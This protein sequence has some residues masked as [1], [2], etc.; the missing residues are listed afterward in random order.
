MYVIIQF[1]SHHCA[2]FHHIPFLMIRYP[3][4]LFWLSSTFCRQWF[5]QTTPLYCPIKK[6]MLNK[7]I[8]PIWSTSNFKGKRSFQKRTV[9][10]ILLFCFW[11]LHKFCD[12][13]SVFTEWR[14]YTKPDCHNGLLQKNIFFLLRKWNSFGLKWIKECVTLSLMTN[15][16]DVQQELL[17]LR[18]TF[19]RSSSQQLEFTWNLKLW[20]ICNHGRVNLERSLQRMMIS[21]RLLF[22][23]N[24]S[25]F[26]VYNLL[27]SNSR[28]WLTIPTSWNKRVG[29]FHQYI[30]SDLPLYLQ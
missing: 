29:F 12:F 17:T 6:I 19:S 27:I 13:C 4:F 7:W 9:W 26:K 21:L 30:S 10:H 1:P 28:P 8:F 25:L 22:Q 15:L 3:I 20:A 18:F 23:V 14:Y 11:F 24:L 16:G 5:N 2:L